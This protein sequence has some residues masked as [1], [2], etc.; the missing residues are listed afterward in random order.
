MFN[1]I[2]TQEIIRLG[3]VIGS[4]CGKPCPCRHREIGNCDGAARS[5]N[6]FSRRG[7]DRCGAHSAREGVGRVGAAWRCKAVIA[8]YLTQKVQDFIRRSGSFS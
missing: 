4:V 2:I 5:Y 6:S 7:E 1:I 3:R 8:E